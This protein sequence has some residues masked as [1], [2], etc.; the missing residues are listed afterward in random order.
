MLCF[1]SLSNSPVT[2][3]MCLILPVNSAIAIHNNVS[4][5]KFNSPPISLVTTKTHTANIISLFLIL[6]NTDLGLFAI[7]IPAIKGRR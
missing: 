4:I 7:I 2:N 3:G 1:P 5:M 6:S